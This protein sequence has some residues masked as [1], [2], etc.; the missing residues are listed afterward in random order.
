MPQCPI[1]G[2]ATERRLLKNTSHTSSSILSLPFL[3]RFPS[4]IFPSLPLLHSHFSPLNGLVA[5]GSLSQGHRDAYS[6]HT[7]VNRKMQPAC[8]LHTI[9]CRLRTIV[10]RES[11]NG[12]HLYLEVI[13]LYSWRIYRSLTCLEDGREVGV[14]RIANNDHRWK[15]SS[16]NV[17]DWTG[18]IGHLG[19]ET[20]D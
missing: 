17:P 20:E 1:A 13:C 5:W 18:R 16:P 4:F 9:V 11:T 14:K 7:I 8:R 12:K 10:C 19:R 3:P 15:I 6:L 2:Y